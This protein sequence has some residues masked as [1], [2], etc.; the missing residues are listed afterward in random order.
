MLDLIREWPPQQVRV[1]PADFTD[2]KLL[3]FD[4]VLQKPRHRTRVWR[5]LKRKPLGRNLVGF[6]NQARANF[7]PTS[8]DTFD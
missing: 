7:L 8:D 5:S 3:R 4:D 2:Q 1:R 6:V